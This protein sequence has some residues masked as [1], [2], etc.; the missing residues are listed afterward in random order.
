MLVL[1][2]HRSIGE[3]GCGPKGE[4]FRKST[5]RKD[6]KLAFLPINLHVQEVGEVLEPFYSCQ[7]SPLQTLSLQLRVRELYPPKPLLET[8]MTSIFSQTI[9]G[10]GWRDADNTN[11][12]TH[13]ALGHNTVLWS[14]WI[15]TVK[16]V[17]ATERVCA[18]LLPLCPCSW[19]S[20][21]WVFRVV[22][23]YILVTTAIAF[24]RKR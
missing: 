14:P 10:D 22:I 18:T 11:S 12:I 17:Q 7:C 16:P 19:S 6:P 21:D 20:K 4:T 24:T 1:E 9:F 8:V 13:L 2:Q 15:K 5:A 23:I 3:M